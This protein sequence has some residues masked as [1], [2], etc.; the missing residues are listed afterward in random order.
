VVAEDKTGDS[1]PL[2][3]IQC[4]EP[5]HIILGSETNAMIAPSELE[6]LVEIPS[7]HDLCAGRTGVTEEDRHGNNRYLP[8][9]HGT[10]PHLWLFPT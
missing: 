10:H 7:G 2:R 1:T 4:P 5:L 8:P 6:G 9:A 3:I